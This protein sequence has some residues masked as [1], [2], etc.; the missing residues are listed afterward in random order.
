MIRHSGAINVVAEA[1]LRGH[2]PLPSEQLLRWSPDVL[3]G[4]RDA[5][6]EQILPQKPPYKSLPALRYGRLVLIPHPLLPNTTHMPVEGY[7]WLTK[8]LHPERF[9]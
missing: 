7:E 2:Q 5:D 6:L 9:K 8:A 4:D 3:V 1:G